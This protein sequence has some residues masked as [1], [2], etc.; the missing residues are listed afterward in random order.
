MLGS[1]NNFFQ[2]HKEPAKNQIWSEEI[3]L[4]RIKENP[5]WRQTSSQRPSAPEG[6]F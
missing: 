6:Y 2:E 4:N 1:I 3:G 5:D